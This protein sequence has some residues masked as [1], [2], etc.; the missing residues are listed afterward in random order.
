MNYREGAGKC[1]TTSSWQWGETLTC[2]VYRFLCNKYSHNDWFQ[3]TNI[4][5]TDSPISLKM[6]NQ[7]CLEPMQS[8]PSTYRKGLNKARGTTQG[9]MADSAQESQAM[10]QWGDGVWVG[11]CRREEEV[12]HCSSLCTVYGNSSVHTVYGDPQAAT[13]ESSSYNKDCRDHKA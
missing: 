10:L 4:T 1:S 8:S 11:S 9:S 3:T 2:S 6:N 13:A 7:L 12:S 5:L